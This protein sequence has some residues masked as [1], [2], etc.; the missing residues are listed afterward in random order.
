M[1]RVSTMLMC[2]TAKD[3]VHL[4]LNHPLDGL[5]G[6]T[7]CIPG[8]RAKIDRM[9][10]HHGD[11]SLVRFGSRHQ[12]ANP[13]CLGTV[14]S[15]PSSCILRVLDGLPQLNTTAGGYSGNEG[16]GQLQLRGGDWPKVRAV[17]LK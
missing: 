5:A 1:Q 3:D 17:V 7:E 11:A 13:A 4:G 12:V 10:M 6:I 2:V 16:V 8:G 9:V 15:A 14:E